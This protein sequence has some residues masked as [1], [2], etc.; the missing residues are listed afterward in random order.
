MTMAVEL[1]VCWLIFPSVSSVTKAKAMV[2]AIGEEK[3]AAT[4]GVEGALAWQGRG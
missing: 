2:H 1:G 4:G 3:R